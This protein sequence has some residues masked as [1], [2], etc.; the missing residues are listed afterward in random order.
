MDVKLHEQ[1]GELRSLYE[2]LKA[3]V[4]LLKSDRRKI[5]WLIMGSLVTGTAAIMTDYIIGV[6]HSVKRT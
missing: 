3:D 4:E 1:Y 6:I 2:T 5:M